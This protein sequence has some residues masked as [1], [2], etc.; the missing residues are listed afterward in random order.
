MAPVIATALFQRRRTGPVAGDERSA[1]HDIAELAAAFVPTRERHLETTTQG[2][3]FIDATRA[4]WPCAALDRLRDIWNGPVT[5]PVAVGVACAG[6]DI[7]HM[8]ALHAFL[9]AVAANWVSAGVR[10][11]PL[12]QTDSQRVLEGAGADD[13]ENAQ[14]PP[15]RR[16]SMISAVRRSAPISPARCMKRNILGCSAANAREDINAKSE[17][18]APGRYRRPGR[19]RQDRADGRAVQGDARQ[20][21]HRRHHQRHLHQ[22]GC[23]ISGAVGLARRRA[24]HRG[25]NRRLSAYRDSGRCL[26]ESRG[27]RR[28]ARKVSLLSIWC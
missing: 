4:A 7:P 12:G 23:G 14:C 16:R 3:A 1:L 10:L 28:H 13:R 17:W 24:H 22:V 8:P 2:R 6:H 11:I 27:G 21:R 26:D 20:L 25:R 15:R 5:Y 18:P 19:I 9:D